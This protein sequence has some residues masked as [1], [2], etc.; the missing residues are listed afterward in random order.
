MGFPTRNKR[1]DLGPTYRDAYPIRNA[2][3]EIGQSVINR[4]FWNEAG[5]CQVTPLA[6]WLCSVSPGSVTI[7]QQALA[8]DP[9]GSLGNVTIQYQQEGYYTISL[10]SS[11]PDEQGNSIATP[12]SHGIVYLAQDQGGS[13]THDGPDNNGVLV[14]SSQSWTVNQ[15]IGDTIYNLTDQSKAQVIS[16]TAT[17]ISG[18]LSGGAGNDWDA[19]DIYV[20]YS[21][22]TRGAVHFSN[23]FTGVIN[24]F[25][26]SGTLVNPWGFMLLAF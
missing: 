22:A 25:N 1:N 9:Y 7:V 21:S 17:T 13:G 12:L 26:N 14:D 18:T 4:S 16:N 20:I 8:W 2:E 11:Y 15:F 19:G 23:G 24:I 10:A 5:L 6:R 3:Y